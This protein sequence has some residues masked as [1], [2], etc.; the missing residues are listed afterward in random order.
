MLNG[1]LFG[2]FSNYYWSLILL[3]N[4]FTSIGLIILNDNIMD[5]QEFF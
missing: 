1:P 4:I 2:K 3:E 5:E